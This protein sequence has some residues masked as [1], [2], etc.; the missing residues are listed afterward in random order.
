MSLIR[1]PES[2][3][4]ASSSWP[5][6]ERVAD[7][8]AV[9][10]DH[11]V[12]GLVLVEHE[13]ATHGVVLA[14]LQLGSLGVDRPERHP[15]A[16]EVEAL[17]AVQDDVVVDGEGDRVLAGQRQLAGMADSTRRS[18]VLGS[19]SSGRSPSRPRTTALTLPCP[20]P[21]APSE[22]NSSQWTRDPREQ[23]LL[24]QAE[25]EGADGH[26]APFRSFD[27]RHLIYQSYRQC[28]SVH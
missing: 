5:G 19:T 16:V 1:R 21:V 13:A 17:A 15:V 28:M 26:P 14:T 7:G 11:R 6:G 25:D 27:L 8:G 3:A 9:L 18:A 4:C 22:P 24:L 10:D 20:C 23:P 12:A 2:R